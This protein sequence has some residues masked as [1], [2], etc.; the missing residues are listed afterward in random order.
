[1]IDTFDQML[2]RGRVRKR[3]VAL[4]L[5]PV[6]L[7]VAARWMIAA[8][9]DAA[10]SY[11][12]VS[13]EA[14]S[15]A[16]PALEAEP[17]HL[18]EA[19]LAWPTGGLDGPEAKRLLERTLSDLVARLDELEGYEAVIWRHERV[20]GRWL[21]E[22]T[23]R[24]KVRHR[25]V[26]VYMKDIGRPKGCEIIY[27]EGLR[28]GKLIS[29]PGGGLIRVLVP[30]VELSPHS[31]LAMSQSRF[32]ITEAGVL[33]VSRM[34]LNDVRR[35]RDDPDAS[36]SLD[37]ITDDE[38]RLRYRSV[39]RYAFPSP[40]RPFAR[41]EAHYDPETF[42]PVAYTFH[43]WPESTGEEPVL[44]GRYVI[45]SFDEAVTPSDPDFDPLN[46]DYNFR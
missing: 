30:P 4:C 18:D 7:V 42:L 46:P 17:E 24:L 23:L 8:P 19:P 14:G 45:E 22:Q 6:A 10:G 34:I 3:V 36:V 29:H 37:Q 15:G 41:M 2:T 20:K 26:S 32:P 9:L 40:D 16:E 5:A 39:H 33:P 35:E 13:H 12:T 44:A 11:A 21:S 43:D 27:V 38:G 1:M 31:S 28:D 25:P